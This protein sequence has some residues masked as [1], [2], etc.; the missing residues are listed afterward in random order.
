MCLLAS[1]LASW[2]ARRG[3][4]TRGARQRLRSGAFAPDCPLVIFVR[5]FG[6]SFRF[7]RAHRRRAPR[8]PQPRRA[9]SFSNAE[10]VRPRIARGICGARRLRPRGR[11]AIGLRAC[12]ALWRWAL[13]AGVG[14][15]N[16]TSSVAC[17]VLR[18]VRLIRCHDI[19]LSE[20]GWAA[21]GSV[22]PPHFLYTGLSR[23]TKSTWMPKR[24]AT[25]WPRA[26]TP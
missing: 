20:S 19:G 17:V 21:R 16:R 12:G 6:P 15:R 24:S 10:A 25:A 14:L 7:P 18:V 4:G 3:W 23:S 2:A 13:R 5:T 8:V 9:Q 11:P 1:G 22:L 26:W